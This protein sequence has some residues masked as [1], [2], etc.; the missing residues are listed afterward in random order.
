MDSFFGFIFDVLI[1][2]I[3]QGIMSAL[4]RPVQIG[5]FVIFAVLFVG[6]FASLAL[7]LSE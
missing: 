2:P 7:S 3:F 6:A 4:P 1:R 5:C